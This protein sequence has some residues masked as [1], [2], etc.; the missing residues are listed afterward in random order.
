MFEGETKQRICFKP[1][2]RVFERSYVDNGIK[3]WLKELSHYSINL[4]A[5]ATQAHS[6]DLSCLYIVPVL[7]PLMKVI[8]TMVINW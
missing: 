5:F 2:N 4:V 7:F 3:E 8:V 1:G 6:S